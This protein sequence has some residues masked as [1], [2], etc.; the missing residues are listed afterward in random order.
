MFRL[1]ALFGL[2][3]LAAATGIIVWSGYGSILEALRVAGWGIVG[4]SLFHVI[5]L[6]ACVIGWHALMPGRTRPSH[7]FLFYILWLRAAV[8]NLMPVARVGGEIVGVRMMMKHGMR[9]S[10]AIATTIVELT[11]SIC[12]VFLFVLIG[13]FLLSLR[14]AD[15]HLSWKLAAGL[16]AS[17]PLIIIMAVVQRIGFFGIL[18]KIFTLMLRDAWKNFAGNIGQLDRAIHLIYRRKKNIL[19]CFFWQVISWSSCTGEIWLGLYFLGHQTSLPDC[20]ILEA[21]IQGAATA[22]FAVPGALGIQEAGFLFFGHLLALPS[23]IAVALAVIRRCR[24][25]IVFLPGLIVW[26]IQEGKWLL[27]KKS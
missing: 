22:G 5:P 19:F 8:N 1:A 25:L 2:L 16:L 18:D 15:D 24:D 9:K 11:L 26:Q 6:F 7:G 14:I 21:L 17:T 10:T 12:A 23:D 3:G 20:L 4:T 27:K 13:V